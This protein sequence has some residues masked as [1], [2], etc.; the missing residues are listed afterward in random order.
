MG[1]ARRG[2]EEASDVRLAVAARLRKARQRARVTQV[3][4]AQRLGKSQ[5]LVCQAETGAARVGERYV[6]AVLKACK[7][8]PRW[9]AP[10]GTARETQEGREYIGI[11]P[12]TLQWVKRDSK[13]D[14]ELCRKYDWWAYRPFI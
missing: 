3:E 9:G 7:L 8:P 2:D 1:G 13:R 14:K 4:L 12:E 10:R 11:D 6:Q 5:T